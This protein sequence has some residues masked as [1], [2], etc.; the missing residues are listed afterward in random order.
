MTTE[1]LAELHRQNALKLYRLQRIQ[2]Q[3]GAGNDLIDS[4]VVEGPDEATIDAS[5]EIARAEYLYWQQHFAQAQPAAPV[6]HQQP[7]PQYTPADFPT[8]ISPQRVATAGPP[9]MLK[10]RERL[11]DPHAIRAAIAAGPAAA[12]AHRQRLHQLAGNKKTPAPLHHAQVGLD[13]T[14]LGDRVRA[15]MVTE[16][17][18]QAALARVRASGF[19]PPAGQDWK[20][21]AKV[22]PAQPSSP[23]VVPHGLPTAPSVR[24]MRKPKLG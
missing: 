14:N 6:Q 8:A 15:G 20:I 19:A 5:V 2:Q 12:A 18:R 7:M 17:E 21:P 24:A 13:M 4:V 10:E 1:E 22:Q 23:L 16:Q 11:T 3:R 9:D